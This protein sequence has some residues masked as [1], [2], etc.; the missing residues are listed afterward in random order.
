[1]SGS[2]AGK[3]PDTGAQHIRD[4]ER[5]LTALEQKTTVRVGR[6]VL[7]EGPDGELLATT[8]GGRT[9]ALSQ[10]TTIVEQTLDVLED[11]EGTGG[12]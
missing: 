12:A 11:D 3:P 9:L 10:P 2:N 5:R 6:W 7:R 8:Q 1:M 4:L